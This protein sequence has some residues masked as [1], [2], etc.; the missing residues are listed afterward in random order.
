MAVAPSKGADQLSEAAAVATGLG[1]RHPE[2]KDRFRSLATR[3]HRLAES[4][5]V[6]SP[7]ALPLTAPIHRNAIN[8]QEADGERF[9]LGIQSLEEQVANLQ[10]R[11]GDWSRSRGI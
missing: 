5:L 4:D 8:L 3:L 11:A 9:L 6:G 7:M 2:L 1:C 10:R